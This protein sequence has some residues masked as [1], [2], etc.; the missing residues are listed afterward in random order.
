MN[1]AHKA[2][3]NSMDYLQGSNVSPDRVRIFRG[4][5]LNLFVVFSAIYSQGSITIASEVLGITQ[6]AVS[7]A[8]S[9]LR[10]AL[11]DELFTRRGTSMVPTPFAKSIID[12]VHSALDSL[13]TGPLGFRQFDPSTSTLNFCIATTPGIEIYLLP[14]LLELLRKEA[15]NVTITSEHLSRHEVE[16]GFSRGDLDM[17][18]SMDPPMYPEILR[19]T[20]RKDK[21]VT[22]TNKNNP[23]IKNGLDQETYLAA[24]HILI[25]SYQSGGGLEE[26][27]FARLGIKRNIVARCGTITSAVKSAEVTNYLLTLGVQ[28]LEVIGLHPDLLIFDFPFPTQQALE[29]FLLW[30]ESVDNDPA[31]QWLRNIIIGLLAKE[32]LET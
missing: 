19:Y 16:S 15:P 18:I 4:I 2:V 23:L 6:S 5:D 9:R 3:V 12:D 30:H 27:E 24:K 21:F 1:G 13:R 32:T 10:N 28:K 22:V 26:I 14:P 31:N 11:N 20:L 25:S 8:L 29:G 7:H 17:A